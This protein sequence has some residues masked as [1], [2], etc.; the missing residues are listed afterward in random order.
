VRT[1]AISLRQV[2]L[3]MLGASAASLLFAVAWPDPPPLAVFVA[4]VLVLA[5]VLA[6]NVQQHR[7]RV[8][9]GNR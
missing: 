1:Y 4:S 6:A 2:V 7:I 3:L 9:L 5:G 8:V